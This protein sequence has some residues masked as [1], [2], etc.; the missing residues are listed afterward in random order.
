MSTTGTRITRD[1]IEAR[2]RE[3]QGDVSGRVEASRG[4]ALQVAAG[5]GIVLLVLAFLLG[6]RRGRKKTTV[7]EI[8]RF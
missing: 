8:R 1:D 4:R 5:A 2:L 3:L 6:K 7:V